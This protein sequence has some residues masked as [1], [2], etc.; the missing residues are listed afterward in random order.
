MESMLSKVQARIDEGEIIIII[1]SLI[2]SFRV[3][4]PK[5]NNSNNTNTNNPNIT[6]TNNT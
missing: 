2:F 3:F 4:N 6:N 1:T 5:T